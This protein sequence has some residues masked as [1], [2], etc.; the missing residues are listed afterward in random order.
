[1]MEM[2]EQICRLERVDDDNVWREFRRGVKRRAWCEI[3]RGKIV[4]LDR[5]IDVIVGRAQLVQAKYR[6]RSI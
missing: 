6:F 5:R 3:A 2:G 4:R 1:M